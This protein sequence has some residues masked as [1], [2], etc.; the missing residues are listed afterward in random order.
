MKKLYCLLLTLF[1]LTV[2]AAEPI[3]KHELQPQGGKSPQQAQTKPETP[4]S[5]ELNKTEKPPKEPLKVK[6][7]I[8]S[9]K[10]AADDV[11]AFPVDI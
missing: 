9:E 6:S 5:R 1:S 10:I 4:P 8:P 2:A 11:V 3:N 7:F